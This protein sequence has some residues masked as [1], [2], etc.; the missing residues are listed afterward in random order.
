M[1]TE[2][3]DRSSSL[4]KVVI[5]WVTGS[6]MGVAGARSNHV[7]VNTRVEVG[8]FLSKVECRGRVPLAHGSARRGHTSSA[9]PLPGPLLQT[10]FQSVDEPDEPLHVRLHPALEAAQRAHGVFLNSLPSVGARGARSRGLRFLSGY[11]ASARWSA[12]TLLTGLALLASAGGPDVAQAQDD[13]SSNVFAAALI[14][15]RANSPVPARTPQITAVLQRLQARSGSSEPVSIL[16]QRLMFFKQQPGCG[17]V[18]FALGQPNAK[19]VFAG[20]GGQMNVC[21]DGQP[22]L[23]AC[24]DRPGVLVPFDGVCHNGKSPI[25]TD[26]V[27]AAIRT[28]TAAGGFTQDQML[29]QWA[30][31]ISV[32]ARAASSASAASGANHSIAPKG[33]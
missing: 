33:K 12:A 11:L 4:H 1:S 21:R 9:A 19:I 27:A 8:M 18:R 30:H 23:R 26:E 25:D 3:C 10:G 5:A 15:G 32:G 24:P 17:R 6:D 22:P 29:K 28:A 2:N 20:F 16:A 31:Q 14:H 13:M 7:A